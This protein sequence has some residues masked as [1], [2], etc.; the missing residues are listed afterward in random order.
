MTHTI[1][2]TIKTDRFTR[3][4]LISKILKFL[5]TLHL[6]KDLKINDQPYQ[7]LEEWLCQQPDNMND[8]ND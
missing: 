8:S 3:E 7:S 5:K 2:F 4:E 6:D 1:T